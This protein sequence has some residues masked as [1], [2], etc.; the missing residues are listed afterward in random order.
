MTCPLPV[1]RITEV[2]STFRCCASPFPTRAP[3]PNRLRRCCATPATDP[4]DLI[5]RDEAHQVEFFYLRPRDIAT[6]VGSGDL[7]L[8]ITGRDLLVDSGV[9]AEEVLDLNFGGAT[10]RW[11]AEPGAIGSSSD[12]VNE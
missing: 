11:A 5:C 8:G 10:F 1:S 9:P 6:Y 12:E 7:D 2:R 3:C 4:K